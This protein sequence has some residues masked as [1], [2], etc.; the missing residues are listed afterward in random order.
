MCVE[1]ITT[2][3]NFPLIRTIFGRIRNSTQKDYETR[4]R[5]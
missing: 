3:E 4:V 5:K 2:T 1:T